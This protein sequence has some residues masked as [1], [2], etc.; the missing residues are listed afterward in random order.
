[1]AERSNIVDFE[2]FRAAR[3]RVRLPLFDEA[4]PPALRLEPQSRPLS[5]REVAHRERMLKHLGYSQ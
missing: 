3:E 4:P 2:R 5:L 1:M